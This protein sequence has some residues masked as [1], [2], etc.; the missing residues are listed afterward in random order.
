MVSDIWH[1]A[2]LDEF[3][4]LAEAPDGIFYGTYRAPSTLDHVMK[5]HLN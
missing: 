5:D 1:M 4:D 3:K 2:E